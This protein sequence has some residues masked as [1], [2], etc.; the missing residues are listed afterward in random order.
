MRRCRAMSIGLT[1]AC[2]AVAVRADEPA[3]T[4]TET[5]PGSA[6]RFEMI[7]IPGGRFAMGSSRLEDG[8]GDDE[9]PRHR[10]VIRPFWMGKTEESPGSVRASSCGRILDRGIDT[11][12]RCRHNGECW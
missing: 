6:V 2:F 11:V 5:I 7:A 3:K 1:V 12:T 9:G 4:Y 10:V 8:R